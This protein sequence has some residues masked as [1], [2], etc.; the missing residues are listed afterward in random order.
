MLFWMSLSVF[1]FSLALIW[2]N[3]V[4]KKNERNLK[5][6]SIRSKIEANEKAKKPKN[7]EAELSAVD[8]KL[9][10]FKRK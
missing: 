5:L 7:S 3:S 9:K 6:K 1:G 2:H 10:D 8:R 4:K